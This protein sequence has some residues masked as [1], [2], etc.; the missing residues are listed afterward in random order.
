M[1]VRSGG[2]EPARGRTIPSSRKGRSAA[3]LAGANGR[4]VAASPER[5]AR[6]AA[7]CRPPPPTS[8]ARAA[9]PTRAE[10]RGQG[11]RGWRGPPVL[12]PKINDASGR[13]QRRAQPRRSVS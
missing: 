13:Q 8:L 11:W 12:G 1:L 5:S 6:R 9:E 3:G 4:G 10:R 7:P 2:C